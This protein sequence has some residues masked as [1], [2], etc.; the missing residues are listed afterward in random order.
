MTLPTAI[1]ILISQLQCDER[2]GIVFQVPMLYNPL[3]KY[4]IPLHY[5]AKFIVPTYALLQKE[6]E[7]SFLRGP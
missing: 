4:Y 2:I 6:T 7:I 3:Y 1:L 5:E